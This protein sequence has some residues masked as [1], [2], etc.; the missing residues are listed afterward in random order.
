MSRELR[1]PGTFSY[2]MSGGPKMSVD[3][4]RRY[5]GYTGKRK[6]WT[7][8]LHEYTLVKHD[9]S[10]S[11][12]DELRSFFMAVAQGPFQTFRFKDLDDYQATDNH[13]TSR[14]PLKNTVTDLWRGDA[15]GTTTHQL[16]K[17]Y[18]IND[19]SVTSGVTAANADSSFTVNDAGSFGTAA[20][21]LINTGMH[22][23]I[24][25]MSDDADEGLFSIAT[26]DPANDKFTVNETLADEGPTASVS[27]Q[28]QYL[29][30]REITKP[31][32]DSHPPGASDTLTIYD[33]DGNEVTK[34]GANGWSIVP[35]TG[36]VTFAG[37]SIPSAGDQYTWDGEFDVPVALTDEMM[38]VVYAYYQGRDWESIKVIEERQ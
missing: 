4:V 18:H 34:G 25:G 12:M 15:A 23:R 20:V 10:I 5:S 9:H 24:T 38:E 21:P 36:I 28:F 33:Q 2:R 1:F 29:Y 31:V 6:N 3:I 8:F 14:P 19:L 7:N 13:N 17:L 16:V 26:V 37:T 22:V 35:T 32:E 30:E 11:D 27:L